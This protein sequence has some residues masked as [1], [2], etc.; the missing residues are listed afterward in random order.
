M[1]YGLV[2]LACLSLTA[3]S[4][5][6]ADQ[7]SSDVADEPAASQQLA[8]IV[9]NMAGQL[10]ADSQ[11]IS[12]D[13]PLAVTSFVMLD[14][15][16]DTNWLGNQLAE[17][18]I[19]QMHSRGFK[20]VEYKSTGHIKVTPHGDYVFS[21]NW[22]DL[23]K[24]HQIDY[25]LTGTMTRQDDGVTVNARIIGMRSDVVVATAQGFIPSSVLGDSSSL[26][27]LRMKDGMLLRTQKELSRDGAAV[28][29][30]RGAK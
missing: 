2:L 21:R 11:Y 29:L 7:Q 20:V 27:R 10:V 18:L 8:M 5:I 28:S 3:C 25:V 23:K 14:T 1:R 30:T 17:S 13:S 9:N 15:L 6:N 26:N 4:T 12:A 16:E 22:K 19:S 24:L